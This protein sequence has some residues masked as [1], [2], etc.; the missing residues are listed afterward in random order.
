[1][2][3]VLKFETS[4]RLIASLSVIVCALVLLTGWVKGPF[5][6]VMKA[7]VITLIVTLLLL[8]LYNKKWFHGLYRLI[9]AEKYVFPVLDGEWRGEIRSNW[10]LVRKMLAISRGEQ[11]GPFDPLNDD[12]GQFDW[13]PPIEVTAIIESGFL[14]FKMTM[15]MD[16]TTRRSETLNAKLDRTETGSPRLRYI[17]RQFD[18]GLDIAP[19]DRESHLGSAELTLSDDGKTL[20]GRYWTDRVSDK[21][22]NTA[23]RLVLRRVEAPAK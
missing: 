21:G 20:N 10:P 1:M 3:S 11:S 17:Y 19:T 9:R 7:G 6:L 15:C 4:V 12:L 23:G 14:D 22:L 18:E 8:P 13:D 5:G 16:G 2:L